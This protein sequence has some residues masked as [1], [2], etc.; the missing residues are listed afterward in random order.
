MDHVKLGCLHTIRRQIQAPEA[1]HACSF[2]TAIHT[3]ISTTAP[4]RDTMLSSKARSESRR[5]YCTHQTVSL[6]C[7]P[8]TNLMSMCRQSYSGGMVLRVLYGYEVTKD[9]DALL[10]IAEDCLLAL[11]NEIASTASV[12]ACDLF[13]FRKLYGLQVKDC[14]Q[15]SSQFVTFH[16]GCQA[17]ISRQKLFY[18]KHKSQHL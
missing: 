12:W 4:R 18:G 3:E 5:L 7:M 6:S 11:S 15:H 10:K 17:P 13:P 14:T 2:R 16:C 1:T 8:V 9:D